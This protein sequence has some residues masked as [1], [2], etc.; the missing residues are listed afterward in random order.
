MTRPHAPRSHQ[1][2]PREL[3]RRR[4]KR[5]AT[6]EGASRMTGND[7]GKAI[8]LPR[9]GVPEGGRW[10]PLAVMRPWGSGRLPLSGMEGR[11]KLHRRGFSRAVHRSRSEQRRIDGSG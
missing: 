9:T 3:Q 6:R 5:Y 2:R 7:V 4:R 8:A 10:R 1:G 11:E